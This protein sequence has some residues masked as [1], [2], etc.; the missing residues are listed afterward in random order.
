MVDVS[1]RETSD[2]ISSEKVEGTAV[3]NKQGE[4]IG[5]IESV[6]IEKRSGK[7]A[8]AV[9]SFGGFLGIGDQH[10]PVPWSSLVYDTKLGGYVI[11]ADRARLEAAPA[12][13]G[14]DVPNWSDREWGQRV[15]QYY[16]VRPYWE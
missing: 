9:M 1:T 2:L 16:G 4:K 6:M 3:M 14:K 13:K 5:S 15:H 10:H 11:D 8:Y 7:V 12:Y